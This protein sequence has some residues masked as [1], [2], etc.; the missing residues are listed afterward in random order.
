MNSL[1]LSLGVHGAVNYC[2]SFDPAPATV[3]TLSMFCKLMARSR[4]LLR[5]GRR[6]LCTVSLALSSQRILPSRPDAHT[7]SSLMLNV[8]ARTQIWGWAPRRPWSSS[9]GA[10]T[11]L[12]AVIGTSGRSYNN[13]PAR[14]QLSIPCAG[15]CRGA[16]RSSASACSDRDACCT[17]AF[18]LIFLGQIWAG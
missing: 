12:R 15:P 14:L 10:P 17:S 2:G 13:C 3:S 4:F 9:P 8:Y 6:Q 5:T 11:F 18:F 16:L 1:V 7:T